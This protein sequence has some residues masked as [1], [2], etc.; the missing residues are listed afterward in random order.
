MDD[1]S[2]ELL[3]AH[4]NDLKEKSPKELTVLL[5]ELCGPVMEAVQTSERASCKLRRLHQVHMS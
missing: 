1:K 4:T 5:G 3:T 2:R